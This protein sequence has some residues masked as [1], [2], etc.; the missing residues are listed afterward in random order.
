MA[1]RSYE[2]SL[3]AA[4][5]LATVAAV[6]GF[7]VL[8][9]DGVRRGHPL[10]P[11]QMIPL[12][13]ACAALA[14]GLQDDERR[15]ARYSAW[16]DVS[17]AP[18]VMTLEGLAERHFSL[19]AF[20]V[21]GDCIASLSSRCCTA[22][23]HN[24]AIVGRRWNGA[25]ATR[26]SALRAP[27]DTVW[28]VTRISRQ[29]GQDPAREPVPP[30]LSRVGTGGLEPIEAGAWEIG[31]SGTSTLNAI[32]RLSPDEYFFRLAL[33]TRRHPPQGPCE[34]LVRL[35]QR[36]DR[37]REAANSQGGSSPFSEA[38][39]QGLSASFAMMRRTAEAQARSGYWSCAGAAA[40]TSIERAL[41]R[42]ARAWRALGAPRAVDLM[43]FLCSKD[44]L[45]ASLRGNERYLLQFPPGGLPPANA[46]WNLSFMPEEPADPMG[47]ASSAI[48]S[49]GRLALDASGSVQILIQRE[50]P[51]S[52]V[53]TNWLRPPKGSFTLA[54]RLHWPTNAAVNGDWSMPAVERRPASWT[55]RRSPGADREGS[56]ARTPQQAGVSE[57]QATACDAPCASGQGE[58]TQS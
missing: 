51:S 35:L 36:L 24:F 19:T 48:S 50:R 44:S 54:M 3:A 53:G 43:Q 37:A 12:P 52:A 18:I 47:P 22:S 25:V 33:L 7:P 4:Y 14:P 39:A 34:R 49:D 30:R 42:A 13:L 15:V 16:I 2:G 57:V 1:L 6:L 32:Q 5:R 20:D 56:A 23:V 40:D 8:L 45:G 38:V 17:E 41:P 21:W 29:A 11:N 31:P 46:F 58:R 26:G 9:V 28:L 27:S 55:R 10:T